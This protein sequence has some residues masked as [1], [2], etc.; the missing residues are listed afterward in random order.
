M[1][2]LLFG[3]TGTLGS[4]IAAE[5]TERGEQVTSASRTGHSPSPD[6]SAV[7]ADPT[8]SDSVAAAAEGYDVIASAVHIDPS[9][10]VPVTKGLLEGARKAGVRRIVFVGGAGS[11]KGPDGVDLVD[12]PAFPAEWRPIGLAH[13][14]ALNVIRPVADLDW[15]YLSP[16]AVIAPGERTGKFRMGGDD[17]ITDD[18][19]NSFISAEDYA[20]A[21]ADELQQGNAIRRRITV[22][23]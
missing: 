16:A 4:R 2:I 10:A 12:G 14:D 6:I 5:L 17:V 21:F 9:N 1:R 11:L 18:K 22:G 20:V 13:R 23:Y 15:S 3:A 19:G 8:D 7:T